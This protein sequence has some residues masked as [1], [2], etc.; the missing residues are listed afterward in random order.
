MLVRRLNT[1][2]R[3]EVCKGR[4][5]RAITTLD[6]WSLGHLHM[7]C[8]AD[9]VRVKTSILINWSIS[10]TEAETDCA[11]QPGSC[12]NHKNLTFMREPDRRPRFSLWR[13]RNPQRLNKKLVEKRQFRLWKKVVIRSFVREIPSCALEWLHPLLFVWTFIQSGG[14][15]LMYASTPAF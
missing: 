13:M 3:L 10:Q 11:Q 12:I 7:Q 8:K 2:S 1:W 9:V 6:K 14:L 5:S 4:E 15:A